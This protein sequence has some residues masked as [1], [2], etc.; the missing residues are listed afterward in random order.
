MTRSMTRRGLRLRLAGWTLFALVVAW[1]MGLVWFIQFAARPVP[2]PPEADGIVALTGGAERVETALRLLQAHRAAWLLLSGIGVGVDLAVLAHRAEV[3]PAPLAARVTLGRQATS[4]R[5]NAQ[6]TAAWA[7]DHDIHT[8]IVVTAY[9]H[10]PRA[11]TELRRALPGVTL[12]PEPVL[13]P[14]SGFLGP[15]VTLR[16]TA[17]E[18]T[19]Y[20]MAL[21]GVT[22]LLPDRE[23]MPPHGA[24]RG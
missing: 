4:T 15:L 20:L 16:L 22:T 11:L 1:D 14:Q 23:Q 9:Y 7:R 6:E 10:M 5:G 2:P 3:D 12:Y 19:K 18:Y 17:E 8:L 24:H 21:V 13:R